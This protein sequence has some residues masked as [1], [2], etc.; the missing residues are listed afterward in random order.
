MLPLVGLLEVQA[1]AFAGA[2]EAAEAEGRVGSNRAAAFRDLGEPRRGNAG[3]LAHL[4]A[5]QVV[6]RDPFLEQNL[7]RRDVG[8]DGQFG[9]HGGWAFE[10]D[11]E[12]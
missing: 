7:A 9:V 11:E 1:E 8:N 12:V 3:A 5:G 6:R 10:R 4:I 2:E